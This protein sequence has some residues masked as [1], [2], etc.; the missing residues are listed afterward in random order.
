MIRRIATLDP[1]T[2]A[3]F[4]RW[5]RED[6]G[7]TIGELLKESGVSQD[8]TLTKFLVYTGRIKG[9]ESNKDSV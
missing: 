6:Q 7:T 5:L 3:A 2:Y 4:C 9:I 8:H 1:D